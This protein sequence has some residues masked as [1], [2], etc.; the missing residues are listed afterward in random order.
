MA[1]WLPVLCPDC[2]WDNIIKHGR[3]HT[4]KQRYLC[5]NAGCLR[6]TFVLNTEQPG[7]KREVKQKIV[8]MALNGSGIRDTARVLHVS[9]VTVIRELK[10]VATAQANK[11]EVVRDAQT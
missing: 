1:V 6:R 8:E 10:K 9:P 4:G 2:G 7:R 11:P 5:Q 3:L